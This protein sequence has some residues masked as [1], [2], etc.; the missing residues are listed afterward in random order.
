MLIGDVNY[1]SLVNEVDAQAILE[2]TYTN[3]ATPLP[4][5]TLVDCSC[6]ESLGGLNTTQLQNMVNVAAEQ[7]SINYTG[8]FGGD[9]IS[10]GN[11]ITN[12]Q[13]NIDN[14]TEA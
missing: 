2:Y 5:D 7:L 12:I 1:D 4:C 13:Q 10:F 3:G 14:Y 8:G 9:C 6:D 11:P